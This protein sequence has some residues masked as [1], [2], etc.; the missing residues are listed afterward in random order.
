MW[1]DNLFKELE[2][3]KMKNKKM[4]A[5]MQNNY[6]GIPK[7]LLKEIEKP[8]LKEGKHDLTE[9]CTAVLAENY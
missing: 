6:L 9:F 8:Y 5:Y 7:P 4:S 1:Y 3:I 2:K